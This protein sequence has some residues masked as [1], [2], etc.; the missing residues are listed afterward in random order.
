MIRP[1]RLK[2]CRVEWDTPVGKGFVGANEDGLDSGLQQ[3][4]S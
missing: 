1:R 3:E 4:S 2:F